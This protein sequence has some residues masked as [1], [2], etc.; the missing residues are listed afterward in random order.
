MGSRVLGSRGVSSLGLEGGGGDHG[1]LRQVEVRDQAALGQGGSERRQARAEPVPRHVQADQ[2]AAEGGLAAAAAASGDG[3]G[4][5]ERR[6]RGTA[7]APEGQQ[8]RRDRA[9]VGRRDQAL[10]MIVGEARAHLARSMKAPKCAAQRSVRL[11]SLRLSAVREMSEGA[12]LPSGGSTPSG[13]TKMAFKPSSLSMLQD[14]SRD[15]NLSH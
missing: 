13:A 8:G 10:P 1:G 12:M 2:R 15:V 3:S 6:Q 7:G 4:D 9:A 14:K 11:F 5:G